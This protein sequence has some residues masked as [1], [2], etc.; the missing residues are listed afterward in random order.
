MISGR[1]NSSEEPVIF[2]YLVIRG[3]RLRK[4]AIID[5]GFNGYLSVPLSLVKGWY[6]FGHEKYEIAT[7]DIVEEKVYLGKIVWDGEIQDVYAVTSHAKDILIGTKLLR[8]N[9]L[10]IDFP[11]K[12]VILRR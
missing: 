5:T 11:K 8:K 6:F 9:K 2:L 7:G 10:F 3:K 4:R 1:I 12:K